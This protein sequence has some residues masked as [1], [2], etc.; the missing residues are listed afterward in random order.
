MHIFSYS[1]GTFHH[2]H[3]A[4]FASLV[5]TKHSMHRCKLYVRSP[6]ERAI[7]S[8]N[9]HTAHVNSMNS[10]KQHQQLKHRQQQQQQ[11][12]KMKIKWEET[13]KQ[14]LVFL[15]LCISLPPLS[16]VFFFFFYFV[17]VSRV[18]N[19]FGYSSS[20]ISFWFFSF[21]FFSE[22]NW[23][24][25]KAKRVL[26]SA[27]TMCTHLFCVEFVNACEKSVRERELVARI[28]NE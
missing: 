15:F 13:L 6:S 3:N 23:I 8:N 9:M 20:S 16:L 2:H 17:Q 27:D 18:W 19:A 7:Y 5:D 1:V 25:T 24:Y 28:Q 10:L 4:Y 12:K 26:H 14:I 21:H 11:Q 22:T